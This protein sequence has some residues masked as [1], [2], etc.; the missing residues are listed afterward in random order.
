MWNTEKQHLILTLNCGAFKWPAV[1]WQASDRLKRD[2]DIGDTVN[3][4]FQIN[5][6]TFNG[7]ENAQMVLLD[8]KKAQ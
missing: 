6:N 5:R 1:F 3:A 4:V 8:V 2:F 7:V